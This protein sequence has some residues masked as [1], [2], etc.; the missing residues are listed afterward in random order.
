MAARSSFRISI[1]CFAAMAMVGSV[2][3]TDDSTAGATSAEALDVCR[4]HPS[5]SE[6]MHG[7]LI[8]GL[9]PDTDAGIIVGAPDAEKYPM[10]VARY[11]DETGLWASSGTRG[12]ELTAAAVA[13]SA[14]TGALIGLAP[15]RHDR[16]VSDSILRTS[17][18]GGQRAR[19]RVL[20]SA[21][22]ERTSTQLDR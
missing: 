12:V 2:L 11:P 17:G 9:M 10:V 21:L 22:L 4:S 3:F 6:V 20:D 14:P 15:A 1:L 13:T 19:H 18:P 8:P 16:E 5:Y 7:V